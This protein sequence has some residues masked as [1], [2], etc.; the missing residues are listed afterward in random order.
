M[1]SRSED[2]LVRDRQDHSKQ[3]IPIDQ[4]RVHLRVNRLDHWKHALSPPK[5]WA[6]IVLSLESGN[7]SFEVPGRPDARKVMPWPTQWILSR[8]LTTEEEIAAGRTT[9]SDGKY[10][11][12]EVVTA[13][14]VETGI[15]L[16]THNGIRCARCGDPVAMSRIFKGLGA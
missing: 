4:P 11:G 6:D 13:E 10:A 3:A 5:G 7:Y 15:K 9:G 16:T 2:E 1:S 14:C 8:V 12:W